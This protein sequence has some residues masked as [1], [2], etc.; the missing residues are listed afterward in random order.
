MEPLADDELLLGR[1]RV[2][3][4]IGTGGFGRIYKAFDTR[5]ERNVALKMIPINPKT[6]PRTIREAKTVA[7]L[8]HSNIVT[9]YEFDQ[10]ERDYVLVMEYI[11]GITLADILRQRARLTVEE[12]AAIAIQV[13]RGLECAHLNHVIHRDVKPQNLMLMRDGRVKVMDFGI[14]R[15][16]HTPVT[17]DGNIRGTLAYMSP[18]QVEG[19]LVD[20]TT[21]LFALGVV[22]YEML[23]GMNPFEAATPGGIVFAVVNKEPPPVSSVLRM[24]RDQASEGDRPCKD[25]PSELDRVL[26]RALAKHPDD[27]FPSAVDFRYKVERFLPPRT[28]VEDI[29]ASLVQ[30]AEVYRPSSTPAP[31]RT[32]PARDA[33]G[34]GILP[35]ADSGADEP[36]AAAELPV[37]LPMNGMRERLNELWERH[38]PLVARLTS[39]CLLGIFTWLAARYAP[40]YPAA[41]QIVLPV[42]VA[43]TTVMVPAVGTALALAGVAPPIYAHSIALGALWTA[44][45]LA[46]WLSLSARQPLASTWPFTAPGFSM[47]R[48]TFAY[49]ILAGLT[50]GPVRAAFLAFLGSTAAIGFQLMTGIAV[51]E[52]KVPTGLTGTWWARLDGV[53]N[54]LV[55][56]AEMVGIVRGRPELL[57]FPVVWAVAAATTSLVST[58]RTPLTFFTAIGAGLTIL[59]LGYQGTAVA[60]GGPAL[61]QLLQHVAF[62][63]LALLLVG[64]LT[65]YEVV[66]VRQKRPVGT[67]D[68]EEE[69]R[70]PRAIG[71][72]SRL[73][74][75]AQRRRSAADDSADDMELFSEPA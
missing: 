36:A 43:L 65:P 16:K 33:V 48:L 18:E 20:E 71:N 58:R 39:G 10:T 59:V 8:N 63:L 62:S 41:A 24:E 72:A 23:T 53:A 21:D 46:Y 22:L 5:M 66:A 27:R 26:A 51:L 49:P 68:G 70:P 40:F 4:T 47:A 50:F 32:R 45:A 14:A 75:R 42:V 57:V 30:E 13:C 1:Y 15:L 6:T 55:P 61:E 25:L 54:P 2:L 56:I 3:D 74:R 31:T 52:T 69:D 11:D 28:R 67:Y 12:A 38:A 35:A 19:E 44:G 29:V 7:L 9:L 17:R 37:G 73:G 34:D 64:V 60:L